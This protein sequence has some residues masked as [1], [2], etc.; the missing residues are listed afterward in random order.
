ML[1]SQ[2]VSCNQWTGDHE[3][4]APEHGLALGFEQRLADQGRDIDRAGAEFGVGIRHRHRRID[5]ISVGIRH[6][7]IYN[8]C[9]HGRKARDDARPVHGSHAARRIPYDHTT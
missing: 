1:P 8:D 5:R 3:P 9:G 4:G 6:C 2:L 7:M